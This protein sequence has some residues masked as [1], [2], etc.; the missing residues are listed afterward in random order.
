MWPIFTEQMAVEQSLQ[1]THQHAEADRLE[2]IKKAKHMVMVC[3]WPKVTTTAELA[4]LRKVCMVRQTARQL[5]FL[6]SI[7]TPTFSY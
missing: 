4:M 2:A 3:A 6:F 7:C 1:E 5:E